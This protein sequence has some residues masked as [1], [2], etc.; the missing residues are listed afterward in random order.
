MAGGGAM[1]ALIAADVLG[2]VPPSSVSTAG[3][4]CAAAQSLAQI[5]ASP[6]IGLGLSKLG[7]YGPIVVALALWNIPG[8]ILWLSWTPPL[9][10]GFRRASDEAAQQ[11]VSS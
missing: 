2:R 11:S 5:L 6:L 8:A 7:G 4:L 10:H 9:P 1:F 3:G